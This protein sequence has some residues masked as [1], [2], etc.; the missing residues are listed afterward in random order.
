MKGNSPMHPGG[1][2]GQRPAGNHM[3]ILK[4]FRYNFHYW[5]RNCYQAEEGQP[6]PQSSE[7]LTHQNGL[8]NNLPSANQSVIQ[9]GKTQSLEGSQT[10]IINSEKASEIEAS[11]PPQTDKPKKAKSDKYMVLQMGQCNDERQDQM[12]IQYLSQN[13][14]AIQHHPGAVQFQVSKTMLATLKKKF[15]NMRAVIP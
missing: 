13:A 2:G 9:H 12:F 5:L 1:Q 11:Q 4:K 8:S 7:Q 6:P 10:Q 14:L 3:D 15:G